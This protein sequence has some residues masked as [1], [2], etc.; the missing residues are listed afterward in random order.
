MTSISTQ[1]TLTFNECPYNNHGLFADHY[2]ED[3]GRLRSLEEW[4]SAKG[5]GEAFQK[6]LQMYNHNAV[7][8]DDETNEPQTERDFIQPVLNILWS[9]KD[10]G[11]CYEVQA[12]I[13]NIN[14]HRR[15]DW[16]FFRNPADRQ[17]AEPQK[18]KL[19]YWKNIPALGDAKRWKASLDKKR[20]VDDNPSGQIANYLYRSGVRWGILTNGRI[21]RLYEREKSR[22]GGIYYE[23]DLERLLE[24]GNIEGFKYFYLFFRR[25]AFVPDTEGLSFVEKVYKE[26]VNYA[27]EVG[28]R[29]K[30]SVYDALCMIMN[31]FIKHPTNELDPTDA[32]TLK[33][34]HD[35]ALIILYRLLF[36]L[37]AEDKKLLPIEIDI[38]KDHC[39]KNIHKEINDR[40]KNGRKYFLMEQ[41]FWDRLKELFKLIDN[42]F[43]DESNYI[44]PAYNGGL[45]NPAKYPHI[46]YTHQQYVKQW[47]IGDYH[48]TTAID[49][50]SYQRKQWDKPGSK[51]IDYNTLDVQHLGSIYEGLLELQ[52]HIADELLVETTLKGK[53]VFKPTSEV[54]NHQSIRGKPSRIVKPDEVYLIN[55]RGERKATGSYYTPKYIVDYI[56]DNTIGT[57]AEKAAKKVDELRPKI[58][59]EIK[60]LQKRRGEFPSDHVE[61]EKT[62]QRIEELK[63]EL[64]EP[65]LSLKILDPAMGSGHF[66]VGAADRLSMELA[67]DPNVL[68]LAEI[69]DEDTQAFYKRVIVERCIYGV[70]LNPLAVELAKLSLWLHTVSKDKALSFL[71]HHLRC[72][73]SLI[74]ARIEDDLQKEP[75]RLNKNGKLVKRDDEQLVL[76]FNEALTAKHLQY[77]LDTFREIMEKTTGDAETERGKEKLYYKM[78]EVRDRFRQVANC[79][80]APYFGEP[81]S[82]E[83]YQQAVD[84]LRSTEADWQKL[85]QETWYN[86]TQ[87]IAGDK[88]FFHWEL[89]FPEIFF[90]PMGL[91]PEDERGFDSVIGNPPYYTL[92]LG[93]KQQKADEKELFFYGER[94]PHASEYKINTFALFTE[95]ALR[96]IKLNGHWGFILPNTLL[97]NYYFKEMRKW[98]ITNFHLQQFIDLR[99]NVFDEAETGGN[100]IIIVKVLSKIHQ[101]L[102]TK[103]T[104]INN[105]FSEELEI[106]SFTDIQQDRLLDMPFTRFLTD[107][108]VIEIIRKIE[109]MS[110]KLGEIAKLYQGIITGNNN[111]Y[112]SKEENNNKY[113]K[114]L[115]GSEIE[116]YSISFNGNYI[117]YEPQ[118][119][120]SNTDSTMFLV[121]SK[122]IIRQTSDHLVA[123][124]DKCQFFTLDSTHVIHPKISHNY[125]IAIINSRLINFVYQQ[126]VPEVGKLF[127][128]VKSINL[129][130]LPIRDISFTTQSQKRS[131]LLNE[132]KELYKSY[133]IEKS[134]IDISKFVEQQLQSIPEHSDVIH[135]LLA[136]LA[137]QMTEM[138]KQKQAEVNGFLSWLERHIG[139]KV[140]DMSNKTKLRAYHDYELD[141]VVNVLI[142]NR[143]KLKANPS[144][145]SFQEK[146]ENELDKSKK[147]L[148][149]LKTRLTATDRLID[150][151]VYKLY[152]LTEDEIRIVEEK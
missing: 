29:L 147:K 60:R 109:I 81:V 6:I 36:L 118:E 151:I 11:D 142:K 139:A 129:K 34:I 116:R 80:L 24:N 40:L 104:V 16:A 120:W 5:V 98:I 7:R 88:H 62:E 90:R 69:A 143:R 30:E 114:I 105:C 74:G 9:D 138:N 67:T 4:N 95:K 58:D 148:N 103:S 144:A 122:I 94:F 93:K 123:A 73:N 37:Y 145:R 15:P 53:S 140:D 127:A 32:A 87:T 45:F 27:I 19:D 13:P 18:G 83:Q 124:L 76:G 51:D 112:L 47:Q 130:Q 131:H 117:Y 141:T 64:I 149:P 107:S 63:W 119:L 82:L 35:N 41:R 61:F 72:G 115:R 59:Q 111:K 26:S 44:I 135:D 8:F 78:D 1:N 42:G 33:E 79:W 22:A 48:L 132:G 108:D 97:T 66:L 128:Q 152:G 25:E 100:T 125:F 70:D 52:P 12:P 146:I 92:T 38:Y 23:V 136:Y 46:A 91:K 77:F 126:I 21:W 75:P 54:S 65:Y 49:M 137:E 110:V 89:E 3:L 68:D 50:L 20:G 39:L 2:L 133:L 121:P 99:F 96:Y 150:L 14:G 86:N 84:A 134:S 43:Q 31:G 71:D 102:I 56:V 55:D 85:Q 101:G 28:E 57:L 10:E 113:K 17:N 106:K